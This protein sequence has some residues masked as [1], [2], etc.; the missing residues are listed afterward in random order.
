MLHGLIY[1]D[2]R[3]KDKDKQNFSSSQKICTEK[4]IKF[5]QDAMFDTPGV[6]GMILFLRSMQSLIVAYHDKHT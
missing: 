5:L 6:K 2:V 3:P 4:I 1:S